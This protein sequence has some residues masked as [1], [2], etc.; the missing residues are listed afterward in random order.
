MTRQ[1]VVVHT[2]SEIAGIREAAQ[3]TARVLEQLS[4]AVVPGMTTLQLDQL[5]GRLIQ[6]T[7]GTSAFYNYHG[8]PGQICISVDDVVVH[9]IGN[10]ALVIQPG[11]LVSIDVGVRLGK[12]VGDCA[13]TVCAGGCPSPQ[14]Q[15]LMAATR[16]SLEAGIAAA[17]AGAYVSDIGRAVEPVARAGGFT[18]VRDFV[19]HGCGGDLHEPP[20]VPN[21]SQPRRGPK[22]VPGMVLCIEPMVNAGG[23]NVF[24]EDDGWTVRTAD[25]GL[26][27]HFEHMVLIT[28]DEPEILTWRRTPSK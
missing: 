13:T 6:E 8:F 21:F 11:Q 27:A 23:A 3:S 28:K 26:S 24:V 2:A 19:G 16:Q 20:E 14:A 17:R 5:A 15:R 4:Q 12:F 1:Q 22:L 18:V 9:G 7:G 10:P 25:G